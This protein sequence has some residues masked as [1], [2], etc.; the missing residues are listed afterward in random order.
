MRAMKLLMLTACVLCGLLLAAC[1]GGDKK[2]SKDCLS[3]VD[4]GLDG[5]ARKHVET[6]VV[7][8]KDVGDADKINV[9]ICRT[10]DSDATA[11]VTVLG[12]R[13]KLIEDQRH[14]LTL[15]RKNSNWVIVRDLDTLRC[16]NGHGHR[17]F[18]SLLCKQN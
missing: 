6:I 14:Q 5:A 13:D 2:A 16:R 17:D 10:S 7:G 1:G 11:V 4:K 15:Q 12:V 18:S 9:D 3:P 8:T